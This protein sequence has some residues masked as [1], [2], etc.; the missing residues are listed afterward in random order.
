[1]RLSNPTPDLRVGVPRRVVLRAAVFGVALGSAGA[2]LAGCSFGATEP[3]SPDPLI[4][5]ADEHHFSASFVQ[6]IPACNPSFI[7]HTVQQCDH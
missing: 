3:E 7:L 5:L 6:G 4:A 2:G 1:M